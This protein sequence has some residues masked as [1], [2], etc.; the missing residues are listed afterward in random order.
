MRGVF[1]AGLHQRKSCE[2][3]S[4]IMWDGTGMMTIRSIA[5]AGI[6]GLYKHD[7]IKRS[8]SRQGSG[9]DPF[10][11]AYYALQAAILHSQSLTARA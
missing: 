6:F 9:S 4:W 5:F 1:W 3:Q 10:Y 8:C 11:I 7:L 2:A